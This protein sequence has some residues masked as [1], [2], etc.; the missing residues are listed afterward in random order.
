MVAG[1]K[2]PH[3]RDTHTLNAAYAEN[4]WSAYHHLG[5]DADDVFQTCGLPRPGTSSRVPRVPYIR[6]KGLAA[7]LLQDPFLGYRL[8]VVEDF[9]PLGLIGAAYAHAPTLR[10]MLAIATS[11]SSLWEEGVTLQLV[12][13]EQV[14]EV[15]YHPEPIGHPLSD[16]I[17]GQHSITS[18]ARFA[19]LLRSTGTRG[20]TVVCRGPAPPFRIPP[21]H[22][23]E[24][25]SFEFDGPHW[26][27][28][29][30]QSDLDAPMPGCH[31][32]LWALL[33]ERL[34][35]E[36]STFARERPVQERLRGVI[37][38]ELSPTFSA[39]TAARSLGMSL[40]SLQG[41]LHGEGTSFQAVYDSER[42]Q[43]ARLLLTETEYSVQQ[44]AFSLGFSSAS[45]FSRFFQRASAESPTQWHFAER[46][47]HVRQARFVARTTPGMEPTR[48]V[49]RCYQRRVMPVAN[50]GAKRI[51]S[52]GAWSSRRRSRR[53][54]HA[55]LRSS[56]A[57]GPLD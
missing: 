30:P 23:L 29:C 28:R 8:S 10:A 47:R 41:K 45:G 32:A 31:P 57:S 21:L 50:Q 12:E 22:G 20:L 19:M 40:R 35:A 4:L 42:L 48:S 7:E 46:V 15:R 25:A 24:G 55:V 2:G 37:R 38:K 26:S 11:H 51:G 1:V 17:N 13:D 43:L 18:V 53:G 6:S 14:A 34:E 27:V 9:D 36:T 3:T 33:C 16:R 44:I 39:D 56:R 5:L 52:A 54:P 49:V